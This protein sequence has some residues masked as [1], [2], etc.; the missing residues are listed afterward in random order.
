MSQSI[1]EYFA[2]H[3]GYRCG[4]CKSPDTNFSHG[5]WAHSLTPEDYE[6]L[7]N[8]GW[9]RS[10]LYCYKP[11]NSQTCCPMYTISCKAL[12][13]KISKSQ[14][15]VLKRFDAYLRGGELE[16]CRTKSETN[17]AEQEP[18]KEVINVRKGIASSPEAGSAISTVLE[19][20]NNNKKK[21]KSS[22][23][24]KPMFNS[25]QNRKYDSESIPGPEPNS[26]SPH[27]ARVRKSKD[28]RL[29]RKKLKMIQKGID[30]STL[31]T[32]KKNEVKE[33]Q[34][35]EFLTA[36]SNAKRTFEIKLVNTKTEEFRETFDESFELYKK[37]QIIIHGD[38]EDECNKKQFKRFLV[39]SPINN[40]ADSYCGSYHQHYYIDKKL[41]AVGVIDILPTALSSVYF[42]YDPDYMSLTLGTFGA[43]REIAFVRNLHTRYNNLMYYYMGFYIHSCTKMRYKGCF[44]PSYLQCPETY[45]WV[46]LDDHL[47]KILEENKYK[48][49]GIDKDSQSSQLEASRQA[50]INKVSILYRRSIFPYEIYELRKGIED[51]EEIQQYCNLVGEVLAER[52]LLYRS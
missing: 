34:L 12:D 44:S 37:Y 46:R 31:T 49:F 17:T 6:G 48:A 25:V 51:K 21:E 40:E 42:F 43:L 10:G 28:I 39:D 11:T 24:S 1:V 36:T 8:R 4:Y 52:L 35:E 15:K 29:E 13:F 27:P 2:E 22:A 47:R 18:T 23:L 9:R 14:K 19:S 16:S 33:K 45:A 30:V 3:E 32:M 7:L 38:K 5:M 50:D 20:C 26:L 41:V